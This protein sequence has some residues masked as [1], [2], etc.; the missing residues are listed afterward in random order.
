MLFIESNQPELLNK[1]LFFRLAYMVTDARLQTK[2][3]VL[4][5]QL[6]ILDSVLTKLDTLDHLVYALSF[7]ISLTNLG[8]WLLL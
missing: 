4:T 5:Q 7:N 2:L 6:Q 1:L 3:T 8:F